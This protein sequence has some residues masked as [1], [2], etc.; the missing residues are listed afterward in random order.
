MPTTLCVQEAEGTGRQEEEQSGEELTYLS[1]LHR[2]L[3]LGQLLPERIPLA[4]EAARVLFQF[5][6]GLVW[7]GQREK[8][9]RERANERE[10]SSA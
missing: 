2:C 8:G 3:Q 9:H 6:K 1:H 10:Q 4:P 7:M 5:L